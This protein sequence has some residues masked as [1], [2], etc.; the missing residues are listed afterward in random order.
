MTDR[1]DISELVRQ[2]T[3]APGGSGPERKAITNGERI[4]RSKWFLLLQRLFAGLTTM[5]GYAG[6]FIFCAAI[7]LLRLNNIRL[8]LN[9]SWLL[10][11]I[12]FLAFPWARVGYRRWRG[13]N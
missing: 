11:S 3:N 12:A 10:I 2:I 8:Q 5:L 13:D 4:T 6:L 7:I 9:K 1:R